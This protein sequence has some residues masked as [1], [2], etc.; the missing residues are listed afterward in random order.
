MVV[1]LSDR[2]ARS[3]RTV[4]FLVEV[5]CVRVCARIQA[6]CHSPVEVSASGLFD[7]TLAFQLISVA[8]NAQACVTLGRA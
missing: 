6:P 4:A 7:H 2:V 8:G 1:T 3:P 5:S